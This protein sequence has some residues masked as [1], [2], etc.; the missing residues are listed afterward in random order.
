MIRRHYLHYPPSSEK[1]IPPSLIDSPNNFT[2]PSAGQ[3]AAVLPYLHNKVI[4]SNFLIKR[5]KKVSSIQIDDSNIIDS[6]S[7]NNI[8]M[9]RLIYIDGRIFCGMRSW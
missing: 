7:N 1:G 6:I 8:I 9:L 5:K 3:S 2:D 4:H